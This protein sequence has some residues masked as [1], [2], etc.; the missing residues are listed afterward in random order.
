MLKVVDGRFVYRQVDYWRGKKF[1][2]NKPLKGKI[3]IDSAYIYAPYV[4]R[5][6]INE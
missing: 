3:K 6:F 5:Y 4:P 1:V 2:Y